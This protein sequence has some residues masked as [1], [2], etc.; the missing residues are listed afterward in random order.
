[1]HILRN[2]AK[3]GNSLIIYVHPGFSNMMSLRFYSV[4]RD[5]NVTVSDAVKICANISVQAP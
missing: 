3:Y 1:M 4:P 5:L 2:K